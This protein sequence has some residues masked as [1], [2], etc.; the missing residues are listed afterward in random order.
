VSA[1]VAFVS[2]RVDWVR[3]AWRAVVS[4]E[5]IDRLKV[6]SNNEPFE[7]T[8]NEVIWYIVYIDPGILLLVLP[9]VGE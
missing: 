4:K 7:L 1:L 5:S 2:V 6:R 8:V 9:I 3:E